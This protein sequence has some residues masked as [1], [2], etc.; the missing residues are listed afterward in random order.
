MQPGNIHLKNLVLERR[1]GYKAIDAHNRVGKADYVVK[2]VLEIKLLGGRFRV[3]KGPDNFSLATNQSKK[4]TV[5]QRLHRK[6]KGPKR[7]ISAPETFLPT[8][9]PT[10]LPL[11]FSGGPTLGNDT[12]QDTRVSLSSLRDWH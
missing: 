2:L 1:T 11:L 6:G 12:Y 10:S 3:R 4:M 7:L 5:Q 9:L 8:S